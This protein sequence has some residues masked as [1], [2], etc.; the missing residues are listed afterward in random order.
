M[1]MKWAFNNPCN[2]K[3]EN[4]KYVLIDADGDRYEQVY[5][6]GPLNKEAALRGWEHMYHQTVVLKDKD[7]D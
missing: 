7:N 3:I 4:E 5:Y 2:L 1:A 6:Y